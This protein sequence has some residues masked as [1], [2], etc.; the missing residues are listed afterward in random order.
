MIDI[1][2]LT[3][4]T[5]LFLIVVG[6]PI[7]SLTFNKSISLVKSDPIIFIAL[8]LLIGLG[9]SSFAAATSYGIIG[10]N[11]Y[12]YILF[13]F[14][15]LGWTLYF[16]KHKK[17]DISKPSGFRKKDLFILL[18]IFFSVYLSSSQW[19]GLFKP[20]LKVGLGPDVGQNLMAAQEI[21]NNGSTWFS[22]LNSIKAFT[23]LYHDIVKEL[24]DEQ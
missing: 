21:S 12:F 9:V 3:F 11:S 14:L 6:F 17:G 10:I 23:D 4:S 16:I 15:I 13:F 7:A 19:N 18:P 8:S 2:I 20:Q 24:S 22:S 5:L 1:I